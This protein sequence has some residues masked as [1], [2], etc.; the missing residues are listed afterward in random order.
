M[1]ISYALAPVAGKITG[2]ATI[3]VRESS[4]RNLQNLT[5]VVFNRHIASKY[6]ATTLSTFNMIKNLPYVLSAFALGALMDLITARVF[7]LI[8]GGVILGLAGAFVMKA[9]RTAQD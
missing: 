9:K 4:S 7:A 8:L 3:M 1:G 5:S 2:L 6:R